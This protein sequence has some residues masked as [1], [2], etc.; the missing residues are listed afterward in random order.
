VEAD[1]AV[2]PAVV[3]GTV[4]IVADVVVGVGGE[5]VTAA[6]KEKIRFTLNQ[7]YGAEIRI[8]CGSAR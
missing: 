7:F 2:T 3:A 5:L 8:F 1:G 4:V 6:A